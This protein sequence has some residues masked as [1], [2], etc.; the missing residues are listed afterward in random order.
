MSASKFTLLEIV[1][2]CNNASDVTSLVST[3]DY[4]RFFADTGALAGIVHRRD[5]PPLEE[6]CGKQKQPVFVFD[7]A[8]KTLCFNTAY[9]TEQQ[10]SAA[11]ASVIDELRASNAWPTLRKW[12]N[13]LYP[14]CSGKKQS[15]P[16]MVER[17][18]SFNFGI[19]TFGV[20]ING[21]VRPAKEG[22]PVRMWIAKRA[23]TKQTWAGYLDNMAAGGI[24]NGDGIFASVVKEC[25]EEADISADIAATAKGA[26]TVQYMM[27]S[28]LGV[29]P[30]TIYV[31]DLELPAD[32][33]PRPNDGEVE[34]FYLWTMDEV[35]AKIRAG[36]F[37]PNCAVCAID[38]MI[39]QGILTAENEPDYLEIIDNIHVYLPFPGV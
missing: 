22:D 5:I 21:I 18:A 29:Q 4:Y 31:F 35:L 34:D 20:H 8:E 24:G 25:A 3:G 16:V 30:D 37:K 7:H 1:K 10:R 23:Q 2:A 28:E 39:R 14:I 11:L 33:V 38:F 9:E 32:F 6:E 17:A 13:E 12:R 15:P 26:G 27:L 36:L 19:R